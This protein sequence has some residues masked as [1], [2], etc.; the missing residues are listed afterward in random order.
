MSEL[1]IDRRRLLKL[2]ISTG[3]LATLPFACISLR[4]DATSELLRFVSDSG[5]PV[6]PV[7]TGI[8]SSDDFA[9]LS[10]LCRYV[11]TAWALDGDLSSYVPR[12]R[13]DLQFKT[14]Q[15]PSY[16]T[17]YES[18]V[19]LHTLV[20]ADTSD[21][22]A[23]ASLLFSNFDLENFAATRLGRARRFVFAE[24]LRHQIPVS[25]AFRSFGLWNYRGYFGGSY[26][27]PS[28]YR[29]GAVRA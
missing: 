8:L 27:A 26:S 9:V 5:I 23:W 12:L 25:G 14:E 10:S 13:A 2:G 16:L 17:E 29:R 19:G 3:V 28:S 18:A 20:G 24:L 4:D 21:D 15:E 7:R 6:D 1:H 22:Q 11:D